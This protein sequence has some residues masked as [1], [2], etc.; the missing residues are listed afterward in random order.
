MKHTIFSKKP[1]IEC[2]MAL[3]VI[4]NDP[5]FSPLYDTAGTFYGE[6]DREKFSIRPHMRGHLVPNI[7]KTS[8]INGSFTE[9][10]GGTEINIEIKP[11]HTVLALII[12]SLLAASYGAGDFISGI[13][14]SNISEILSGLTILASFSIIFLLLFFFGI[15]RPIKRYINTFNEIFK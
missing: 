14:S 6:V 15:S 5:A 1:L 3:K 12:I 11:P 7:N 9:K 10:K 8:Q 4:T 2:Y 13:L